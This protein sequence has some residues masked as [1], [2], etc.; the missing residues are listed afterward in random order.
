M[1][2][3]QNPQAARKPSDVEIFLNVL[4]NLVGSFAAKH[5]DARTATDL[6]INLARETT[7]QLAALGVCDPT[8]MCLDGLPLA[9]I[10]GRPTVNPSGI[11]QNLG[12]GLGNG[13]SRQGAMVAQFE[14][15]NVQKVHGL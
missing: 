4:P 13:R 7:G 11:P 2:E 6:A 5:N 3:T 9:I 8:S 14:N 15:Q 1:E 12:Q 10:G